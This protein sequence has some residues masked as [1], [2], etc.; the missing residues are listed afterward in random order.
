VETGFDRRPDALRF[1]QEAGQESRLYWLR[2]PAQGDEGSFH[3]ELAVAVAE[4]G[5][6][7]TPEE[8]ER[9]RNELAALYPDR[10]KAFFD[11]EFPAVGARARRMVGPAG[12]GG[13]SYGLVFTTHDDRFDVRLTILN[14]APADV[15]LPDYD[16]LRVAKRIAEAY[17]DKRR[18]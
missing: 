2:I 1:G 5:T 6:M 13:A 15:D 12:P 8:W 17:E 10:D 3:F 16:L 18:N 7:L 4:A 14:Q 11:H 9:K